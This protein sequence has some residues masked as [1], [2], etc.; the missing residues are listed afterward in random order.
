MIQ[1]DVERTMAQIVQL[2][3][4]DADRVLRVSAKSGFGIPELID[5]ILSDVPSPPSSRLPYSEAKLLNPR[6]LLFDSFYDEYR[7]P[8]CYVYVA[9]GVLRKGDAVRTL[10]LERDY[11][12]LEIGILRPGA[13][14]PRD[15]LGPGQVGYIICGMKSTKEARI[16]DTFTLTR[17]AKSNS[18]TPL[19]GFAPPKSMVFA[20]I[21]P[22]DSSEF[23][24]LS[25]AI[26]R[27]TL[28][29]SSVR[30]ERESS[31]ALGLG[32]RCGFLGM[33]HMDVFRQRLEQEY[34]AEVI[35]TPPTVPYRGLFITL[36]VVSSFLF[37]I[38]SSSLHFVSDP[39][40]HCFPLCLRL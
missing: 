1:A 26:E 5:R 12:I 27:L 28:N 30:V 2:L 11:E 13:L 19:P 8:V 25:D 20:G 3:G 4:G 34:G 18:V 16:G 14:L 32:F 37:V 33:L 7:G 36:N 9:D 15:H 31:N 38:A 29:D 22:I 23:D 21:F 24:G 6:A 10:G 35:V 17:F 39:L 40:Y